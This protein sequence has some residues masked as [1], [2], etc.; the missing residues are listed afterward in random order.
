MRLSRRRVGVALFLT[1]LGQATGMA[2]LDEEP[3]PV[4]H[5]VEIE[6]LV[7]RPAE[8]T[9]RLGDTVEW[10]N[11]DLMP[12]T[13]TGEGRS[14]DTGSIPPGESR[15]VAPTEAGEFDYVCLFHPTMEGTLR[16]LDQRP[17]H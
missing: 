3:R 2:A 13:A 11:L 14:F 15:R 16:V 10:R 7:Y 1:L 17:I 8:L 12:H 6:G 9:I 5:V 4:V